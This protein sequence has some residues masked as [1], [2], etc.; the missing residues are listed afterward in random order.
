MAAHS[1]NPSTWEMSVSS[2]PACSH[3]EIQDSK[4]YRVRP[5]AGWFPMEIH[6][7]CTRTIISTGRITRSVVRSLFYFHTL[8]NVHL[9]VPWDAEILIH[10]PSKLKTKILSSFLYLLIIICIACKLFLSYSPLPSLSTSS[11]SFAHRMLFSNVQSL[12]TVF[13]G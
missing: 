9:P 4:S 12:H 2:R 3:S 8:Q 13:M 10:Y 7:E 11:F 1:C 5:Q 6:Q